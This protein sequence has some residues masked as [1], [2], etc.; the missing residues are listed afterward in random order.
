M[1]RFYNELRDNKLTYASVAFLVLLVIWSLLALYGATG[2]SRQPSLSPQ[3]QAVLAAAP[4]S[5]DTQPVVELSTPNRILIPDVNIGLD[6]VDST[7]DVQTS[8]WPLSDENVH[9]ANFTSSLGNERGTMVLYGHNSWPVLRNA[10]DLVVGNR[11]FLV[12][13]NGKSWEFQLAEVKEV[14]PDQVGFIYEDTPF[15][16]VIITCNGWADEYRRLFYFQPV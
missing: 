13:E 7:I 14:T 10:N 9:Y 11:M 8:T 2:I 4:A 6:V 5:Q 15:R 1:Q 12:D 3:D 16:V